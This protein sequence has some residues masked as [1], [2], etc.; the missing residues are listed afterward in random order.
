MR[1]RLKPDAGSTSFE[2][3]SE[4][5]VLEPHAR[6]VREQ[7]ASIAHYKKMYDRAS[8]L[9]RIGVWECDLATEELI[10]TDGV[11]DLFELPRGTP[12]DRSKI[13]DLYFPESRREMERL[14]AAAISEG[15]SCALD[16]R[17]RTAKGNERWL[18]LSMDVEQENGR[19]VRIF[20]TKQDI[21]EAKAAQD[22]VRVL[23]AEQI[24]VSRASAMAAM[25]ATLA[26]ELNQPL[27]AIAHYAAGALR[28]VEGDE[29][30][31]DFVR[32][33]LEEIGK[34]ALTAGTIIRS[35]REMANGRAMPRQKIDVNALVRDA[36]G[37]AVT[38][39]DQG[40]MLLYAL[41]DGLIVW[42]EPIPLQ[43]VLINIVR[44]AVE[45][46]QES[47]RRR[48]IVSTSAV[49]DAVEIRIDDTGPGIPRPMLDTLFEAFVSSKPGSLGIGLSICRTIV[50][51]HGGKIAA[52]NR[53]GGGA[54]FCVTL[55]VEGRYPA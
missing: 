47:H 52:S 41:S 40:I 9:A 13:L 49:G 45:A 43:Q 48:I 1:T 4:P 20:G 11:Y 34:C 30:A 15:G 19:S 17:V 31:T 33:G 38:E 27:T 5:I 21:T 29:P 42:A 50:E 51:G 44:N 46:V 18:R 53:R 55:P 24:R 16:I 25:G 8:A 54:S 3:I 37:L 10:W 26:H 35:L 7:A 22:K 39:A 12:L 32:H 6:L 28:G 2:R 14:R 23:Q 36:G